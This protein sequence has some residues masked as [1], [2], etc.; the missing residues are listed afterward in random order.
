MRRSLL[1]FLFLCFVFGCATKYG[2]RKTYAYTRTVTA[3]NIPVNDQ[4]HPQAKGAQKTYLVYIE[5]EDTITKPQWD[6]A[7]ILNSK[8]RIQ[9][10]KID[11]D[12]I[13][14]GRSAQGQ[15]E[16]SLKAQPGWQLW[17]L[18]LTPLP[19]SPQIIDKQENSE[20]L[21]SGQWK[22]KA[23]SYRI[24]EIIELEKLFME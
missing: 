8:F 11:Q 1:L 16:I 2:I 5:T 6:T 18:L 4:G 19:S 17:Q 10:L 24:K 13:T 14:I 3:G 9:P 7:E 23:V 15:T 21:I 22:G 12:I 20:I